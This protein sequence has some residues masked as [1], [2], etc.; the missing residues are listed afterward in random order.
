MSVFG[1]A[2]VIALVCQGLVFS[3]AR[4]TVRTYSNAEYNYSLAYPAGW[5]IS[6]VPVKAGPVLYNYSPSFNKGQGLFP[7]GGAE[8]FV[9]PPADLDSTDRRRSP[10]ELAK[11]NVLRFAHGGAALEK[12]ANPGNPDISDLVRV[13]YDYERIEDEELQRDVIFYFRFGGEP[14]AL[15]LNYWKGDPKA[16][17]YD[18]A[19]L[20]VLK[21]I[22][23]IAAKPK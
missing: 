23:H 4:E 21:N 1:P 3:A 5:H 15:G 9:L 7:L 12:L 13:S 22:R 8:I 11:E 17:S 20:L 6:V 18:Q 16:A 14:F 10:E 19:V 2:V